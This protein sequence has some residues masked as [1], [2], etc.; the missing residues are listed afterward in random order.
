MLPD[1]KIMCHL[2]GFEK[3][4][5]D[6]VV[7]HK[8][9]K[10]V[11][12]KGVATDGKTAIDLYDCA[13]HWGPQISQQATAQLSAQLDTVAKSIDALRDEVTN[14]KDQAI[15]TSINQLNRQVETHVLRV[16]QLPPQGH[17][18]PLLT[19]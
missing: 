18:T 9:R 1:E 17:S 5:L 16:D 3:R 13:D 14:H 12:L 6:M 2:T 10:W 15:A 19:G 7:N 4:C 8:C 11:H